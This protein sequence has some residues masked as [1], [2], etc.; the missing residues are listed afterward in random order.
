M[1]RFD[2]TMY[3]F[4]P[5]ACLDAFEAYTAEL[6]TNPK[7]ECPLQ[8]SVRKT[9]NPTQCT[10]LQVTMKAVPV[11][12]KPQTKPTPVKA[13]FILSISEE[14]DPIYITA[15]IPDPNDPE[16]KAASKF[17]P[18]F[19]TTINDCGKLG[20]L[21]DKYLDP[22]WAR[23]IAQIVATEGTPMYQSTTPINPLVKRVNSSKN[24]V[25]VEH[26]GKPKENPVIRFKPDFGKWPSKH[27]KEI[28]RDTQKTQIFDFTKSVKNPKTGL[29]QG[30]LAV[31]KR[32]KPLAKETCHEIIK[33][34]GR[35]RK[36]HIY[37]DSGSQSETYISWQQ[38][39]G[40]TYYEPPAP[41]RHSDEQEADEA[42]AMQEEFAAPT[43]EP[44]Q[45]PQ[46]DAADMVMNS[47]GL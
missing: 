44:V 26:R 6:K 10:Y 36:V 39:L 27:P 2:N 16:K 40:K 31:D 3:V 8:I 4:S 14:D 45:Q 11:T 29:L 24:T 42:D 15:D 22:E 30:P 33:R 34:G 13:P 19:N 1:S 7:A 17:G 5:Q 47:M 20:E 43:E 28:L 46:E 18:V 32:G 23:Q 9:K 12:T 25:P 21:Y 38:L 35:I 41:A 37:L